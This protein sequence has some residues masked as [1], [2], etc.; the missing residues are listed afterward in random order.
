MALAGIV[1][2]LVQPLTGLSKKV[3]P[4][5]PLN[6]W[7][8]EFAKGTRLSDWEVVNDPT[9]RPRKVLRNRNRSGQGDAHSTAT[10]GRELPAGSTSHRVVGV[11]YAKAEDLKQ[12][13]RNLVWQLQMAGSPILALST[14]KT[15][16]GY[17][18]QLVHRVGGRET[19]ITLGAIRWG[20][21]LYL[22]V[23]AVLAD[24]GGQAKV[25][26]GFGE[27]ADLDDDPVLD[28]TGDTY[29]ADIGHDT[30]GQYA[31]HS[32]PGEYI[33]FVDIFGRGKTA[34][35]AREQAGPIAA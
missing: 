35:E 23:F 30:I 7:F 19:R 29:Q 24:R 13:G 26:V 25:W 15:S 22:D 34:A 9:G 4:L 1:T 11:L 17:V 16:A 18:W 33:C 8:L 14:K 20:E 28:I 32:S 12:T 5:G 21:W 3:L 27:L 31:E 10:T 2:R 6:E